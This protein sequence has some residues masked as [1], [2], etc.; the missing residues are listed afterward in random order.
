MTLTNPEAEAALIHALVL[1]PGQVLSVSDLDREDFSSP[2]QADA[3]VAILQLVQ[4]NKIVDVLA[5]KRMGIEIDPVEIAGRYSPAIEY[6]TLIREASYRRRVMEAASTIA[7]G[8]ET[9]DEDELIA[10]VE[11]AVSGIRERKAKTASMGVL[12]LADYRNAPPSPLL[13]VLSPE[14]TT[15]LYGDG[16][17]GKGWIAASLI[18]DLLKQGIKTAILDFE[19]HPNEWAYRL[20]KL[21]VPVEQVLYVQPS[22][23]MVR[24]ANPYTAR[25]LRSE[26]V[27]MLVV[28]SAMYASNADDP[29]S[30]QSA[31]QYKRARSMLGNLPVLLLAHTPKGGDSIFGSAFWRNEARITWHLRKDFMTRQRH[32]ECKKSNSYGYLEGS[33]MAVEFD[34]DRGICIL[35]PHGQPWSPVPLTTPE[36]EGT[37]PEW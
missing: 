13:G 21:G 24:W 5:L 32:L 1:D 10:L 20:D 23:T 17:D 31:M 2:A 25:L 11:E 9:A 4:D 16:G 19:A 12:P 8:A 14:G 3:Y 15:I 22:G 36:P 34:E 33:K 37:M 27:G 35:H 18:G 6:A 30:P 7:H 26:D 29:Y 28:D